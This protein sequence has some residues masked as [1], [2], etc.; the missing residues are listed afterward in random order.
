MEVKGEEFVFS[1]EV[2]GN[3][4]KLMVHEFSILHYEN[5]PI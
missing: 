4:E 5:M 1:V 3:K 2:K